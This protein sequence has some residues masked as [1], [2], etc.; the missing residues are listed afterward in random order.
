MVVFFLCASAGSVAKLGLSGHFFDNTL[1]LDLGIISKVS[2]KLEWTGKSIVICGD[3]PSEK[4]MIDGL[5][6]GLSIYQPRKLAVNRGL[7]QV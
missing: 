7:R 6:M 1:S 4:H 5:F 3:H 2:R